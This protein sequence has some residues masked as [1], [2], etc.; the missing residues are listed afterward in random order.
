MRPRDVPHP[1]DVHDFP[2]VMFRQKF[3]EKRLNPA[4]VADEH[5]FCQRCPLLHP[6]RTEFHSAV[7]RFRNRIATNNRFQLL[8]REFRAR[9]TGGKLVAVIVRGRIDRLGA[10]V[11]VRNFF[12]P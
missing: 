2:G 10:G 7:L 11:P 4:V 8:E 3:V 12:P 5:D 9:V 1:L 6:D